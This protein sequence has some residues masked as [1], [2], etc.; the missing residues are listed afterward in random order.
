MK[1]RAALRAATAAE[2]DRVD[3]LFSRLDLARRDDYRLFLLAQAAAFLPVEAALDKAG[4]QAVVFDWVERRRGH[5]L[6]QDLE[7]L[8]GALPAPEPAPAYTDAAAIWGAVYVLEGSRLG[9]AMLRGGVAAD[10]PLAFLTAPQPRGGWR[11]LLELLD[12]RLYE[13]ATIDAAIGAARRTF[14]CFEAGG[15]RFLES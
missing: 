6:V 13:T 1:A 12:D 7:A 14:C 5:L 10:A 4:A 9:G 8:G 2:H 3:A 11:K 15:L